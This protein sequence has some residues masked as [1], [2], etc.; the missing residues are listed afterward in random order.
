MCRRSLREAAKRERGGRVVLDVEETGSGKRNDRPGLVRIMEAV[1][2][3]K[4]DVLIVWKVDRFGRSNIDLLKNIEALRAAG[5]TLLSCSQNIRITPEAD[6][7]SMFT[8][9]VL[10]AAAEFERE[11]AAERSAEWL[12]YAREKG[13][14]IGRPRA[15]ASETLLNRATD[16]RIHVPGG[17]FLPWRKVVAALKREGFHNVPNFATLARLVQNSPPSRGRGKRRKS[18]TS[19]RAA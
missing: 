5:G 17:P 15:P 16:L 13:I 18:R 1:E 19:R 8:L 11:L 6:A 2:A 10:A 9:R 3:R 7:A 14:P 12:A 4:F